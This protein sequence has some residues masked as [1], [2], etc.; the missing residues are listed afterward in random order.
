MPGYKT[1]KITKCGELFKSKSKTS[2]CPKWQTRKK[3]FQKCY[4]A[5][6]GLKVN[7]ITVIIF[8]M[9][10]INFKHTELNCRSVT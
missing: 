9:V 2:T 1:F 3:S 5:L 6:L 4:D 8:E 7:P 10:P